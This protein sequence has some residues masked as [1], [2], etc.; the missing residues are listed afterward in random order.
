MV[1]SPQGN[2][3]HIVVRDTSISPNPTVLL[4]IQ[5]G[6]A[7]MFSIY[8]AH[9]FRTNVSDVQIGVSAHDSADFIAT[10]INDKA[11]ILRV[12]EKPVIVFEEWTTNF[13]ANLTY[14]NDK[15]DR[16]RYLYKINVVYAGP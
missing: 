5:S 6:S 11:S 12:Y 9:S 1:A 3:T 15:L 2:L 7:S 8:N 16:F 14:T 4:S 10:I 13:A